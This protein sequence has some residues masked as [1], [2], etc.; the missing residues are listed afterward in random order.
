MRS[1]KVLSDCENNHENYMLIESSD[2][3]DD[4]E[5]YVSFAGQMVRATGLA[6]LNECLPHIVLETKNN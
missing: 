4:I 6:W 3:I 5:P 2:R 1:W